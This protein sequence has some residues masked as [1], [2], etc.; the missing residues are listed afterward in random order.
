MSLISLVTSLLLASGVCPEQPHA[1]ET[2]AVRTFA[3]SGV[4]HSGAT[5]SGTVTIDSDLGKVIA[6]RIL[7]SG[8]QEMQ[9]ERLAAQSSAGYA[10]IVWM[11]PK[12]RQWPQFIMGERT[13]PSSLKDYKGGP[14]GPQSDVLSSD[15]SADVLQSGKLTLLFTEPSCPKLMS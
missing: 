9:F 10:Y 6:V 14:L 3:A 1:S 2:G 8:G 12:D 7:I 15:G 13:S 11:A 4:F 5:L